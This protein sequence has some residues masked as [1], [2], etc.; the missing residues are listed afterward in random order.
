MTEHLQHLCSQYH[1]RCDTALC[2][3]LLNFAHVLYLFYV[4]IYLGKV[5]PTS[6][7]R[8]ENQGGESELWGLVGWW[9]GV[10]RK[11]G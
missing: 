9:E 1:G 2:H 4:I 10:P 8:Q 6:I 7:E 3:I 5:M 11:K